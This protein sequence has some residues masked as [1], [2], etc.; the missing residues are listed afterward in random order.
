M[1]KAEISRKTNETDIKVYLDIDGTG[2]YEI[3]TGSGFLNHMLELFAKHG[4]FDLDV[5]CKGDKEVDF[6]HSTEDI[7][8]VLGKCFKEALGDKKGINRYADILMPMDEALVSVA[9]D[10]SGRSYL[11]FNANMPAEK[12]G[13]FDTELVREFFEAFT[14]ELGITLHINLMYGNNTHHIIE[15]IFKGVSR[16]LKSALKINK[17][18][19]DEIPSTKGVL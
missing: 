12:V 13:A 6:H 1:R 17:E 19:K 10:V 11:V 8:I 2:E 16:C 15:G 14:R 7:G 9:V 3:N 4:R 18:I 5:S